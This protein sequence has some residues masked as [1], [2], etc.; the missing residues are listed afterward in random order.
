MSKLSLLLVICFGVR[1]LTVCAA[2]PWITLV[3][4]AVGCPYNYL[5]DAAFTI[6][7]DRCRLSSALFWLP[8]KAGSNFHTTFSLW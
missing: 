1:S 3:I 8:L 2:R 4:P 7:Y 5:S 6:C